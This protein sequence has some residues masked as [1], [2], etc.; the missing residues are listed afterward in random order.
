MVVSL[1]KKNYMHYNNRSGG[2]E[3]QLQH[4]FIAHRN[5]YPSE[6]YT[7]NRT[8]KHIASCHAQPT[9][10]FLKGNNCVIKS[11]N[12]LYKDDRHKSS[13]SW[14]KGLQPM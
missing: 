13:H 2:M 8:K 10:Y 11:N 7:G 4:T 1:D 6:A 3:T 9:I 5:P 12:P 14:I